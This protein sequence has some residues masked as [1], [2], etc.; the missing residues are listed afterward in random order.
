MMNL[1]HDE[2]IFHQRFSV[3]EQGLGVNIHR[4][5]GELA[6]GHLSMVPVNI[7]KFYY[8]CKPW[9]QTLSL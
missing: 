3:I 4:L 5:Q 9:S 2:A 6:L 7:L 1:L 8:H